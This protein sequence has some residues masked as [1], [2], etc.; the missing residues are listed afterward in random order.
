M[1]ELANTFS[2]SYSRHGMFSECLRK[3][4]LSYYGSWG[5]WGRGAERAHPG[6]LPSEEPHLDGDVAGD[7][8]A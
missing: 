7:G 6:A 8:G 1:G 3:Y 4:W 2:W 5:G